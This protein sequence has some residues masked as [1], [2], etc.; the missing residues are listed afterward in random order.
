MEKNVF[1]V[2]GDFLKNEYS[3]L[4]VDSRKKFVGCKFG[5]SDRFYI[6]YISYLYGKFTLTYRKD[7]NDNK[8][9]REK[10]VESD[11]SDILL[12]VTRIINDSI[13]NKPDKIVSKNK[14]RSN[15]KKIKKY[16][17]FIILY[18]DIK[19]YELNIQ[20]YLYNYFIQKKLITVVDF[21]LYDFDFTNEDKLIISKISYLKNF[22][23]STSTFSI[24]NYK[25]LL[26]SSFKDNF[27]NEDYLRY[28]NFSICVGNLTFNLVSKLF[29]ERNACI[30]F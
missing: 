1:E 4:V 26:K 14:S 22:F 18:K 8:V 10:L 9:I 15:N 2:V 20:P 24:D 30:F 3:E 29:S 19:L 13:I 25:F 28:I 16:K 23:L 11:I 12:K 6:M 5:K 17:D 27:K 21:L 7:I